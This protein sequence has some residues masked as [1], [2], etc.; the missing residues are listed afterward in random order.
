MRVP[1]KL[2][3]GA[4]VALSGVFCA[5]M[6]TEWLPGLT[7]AGETLSPMLV[8]VAV[9][10]PV[11]AG[12]TDAF[13]TTSAGLCG[14]GFFGVG[15]ASPPLAPSPASPSRKTPLQEPQASAP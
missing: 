15:L 7:K 11:A 12:A 4:V 2:Q 5:K 14:G 10:A 1:L 13:V 8:V 3:V 9:G 6:L